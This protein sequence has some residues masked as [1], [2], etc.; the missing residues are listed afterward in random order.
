MGDA[1]VC[2]ECQ[3]GSMAVWRCVGAWC[4]MCRDMLVWEVCGVVLGVWCLYM[5]AGIY[6]IQVYGVYERM[7]R[8]VHDM[9]A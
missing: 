9:C 6:W 1:E 2:V 3:T 5:S 8:C 7:H 4:R